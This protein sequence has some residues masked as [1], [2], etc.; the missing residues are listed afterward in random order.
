MVNGVTALTV[1]S[2][3]SFLAGCRYSPTPNF[4]ISDK[5]LFVRGWTEPELRKIIAEFEHIYSDR[6]PAGFR[7]D[8]KSD[9]HGVLRVTFPADIEPRFFCWLINYVQYPKDLGFS[10]RRILVAGIATIAADF[11]PSSGESFVGKRI[12]FYIPAHDKDYDVVYGRVDGKSYEYPFSSE[13]WRRVQDPR[14]PDG[15]T[16]VSPPNQATP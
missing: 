2:I 7:T 10:S 12:L 11:L 5:T 16:E 1:M 9:D 8:I 15:I 13:R 6:L 3:L 14:L 4:Q